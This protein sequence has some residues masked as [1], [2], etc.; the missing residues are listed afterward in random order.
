[1]I[2]SMWMTREVATVEPDVPITAALVLMAKRHVRRLPVIESQDSDA[3][4]V[5]MVTATDIRHAY[6]RDVNPFSVTAPDALEISTTIGDIMS[7]HVVTTAPDAPIENA[8]AEM[9]NRRIGALPVLRNAALVGLITESDIFRAFVA[10]MRSPE[11][12][13]RITFDASRHEDLFGL[14]ADVA[15]E[16]NVRVL[17]L[18]S[19]QEQDRPVCVVRVAGPGVDAMLD[20]LWSSGHAVLNVLRLP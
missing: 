10:V 3:H 5:G 16:H 7:R 18:I 6:P 20:N 17:S 15:R 19:A 4:L 13:A 8:A 14:V 2:V 11:A 12:G 1:M 9:R